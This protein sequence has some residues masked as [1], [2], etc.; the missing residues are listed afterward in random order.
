MA[1]ETD[2]TQLEMFVKQEKVKVERGNRWMQKRTKGDINVDRS[3]DVGYEMLHV[4]ESETFRIDETAC[5]D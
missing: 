3:S 4:L 5:T 2:Q 1:R